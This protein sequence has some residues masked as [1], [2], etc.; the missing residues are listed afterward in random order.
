MGPATYDQLL[1]ANDTPISLCAPDPRP[2]WSAWPTPSGRDDAEV[3]LYGERD[4]AVH[5]HSARRGAVPGLVSELLAAGTAEG[6]ERLVR[7]MLH[8]ME[9]EWLAYGTVV[10]TRGVS[11]PRSFFCHYA[12][13]AWTHRYFR[14]RY[15]EID[16]RHQDAPASS[17]PLVWDIHDLDRSAAART[18]LGRGRRFLDDFRDSG[19]RSGVFFSVASPVHLHQ[20]TVISLASSSPS[21]RWI[22]E[23][24]VGQAL[25]LGLSLHEFLTRHAQIHQAHDEDRT[26]L[27]ALHRD[28]LGCLVRGQSDK[29]IAQ[30]LQLSLHKVDYHLRQLRRRFSVRNRVELVNAAIQACSLG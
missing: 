2:A 30:R 20:R 6:R 22:V 13:P 17:L 25:T 16:P 10:Q 21:R 23:S 7:S 4:L 18:A 1:R 24:V 26:P 29:E 19:M 15:H 14:E 12:H 8:G 28:I 5:D 11:V 3:V 27:S 9:F